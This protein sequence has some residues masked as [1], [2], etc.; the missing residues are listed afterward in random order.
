MKSMEKN[1]RSVVIFLLIFSMFLAFNIS[2]NSAPITSPYL[3]IHY[4]KNDINYSIL[5]PHIENFT[6]NYLIFSEKD[7]E[8]WFAV[9]YNFN[10]SYFYAYFTD[11]QEQLLIQAFT[12]NITNV[13]NYIKENNF[14]RDYNDFYTYNPS[15]FHKYDSIIQIDETWYLA[16]YNLKFTPYPLLDNIAILFIFLTALGFIGTG[17]FGWKYKKTK[18]KMILVGLVI[19]LIIAIFLLSLTLTWIYVNTLICY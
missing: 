7:N 11:E 8:L 10:Q 5:E 16:S 18:S 15:D 17:L 3:K 6:K 12:K 1:Y 9:Y 14:T 4:N 13:L 19:L 2:I